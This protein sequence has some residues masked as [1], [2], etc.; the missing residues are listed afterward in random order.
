MK[1]CTKCKNPKEE[2]YFRKNKR[3]KDGLDL[4]CKICRKEDDIRIYNKNLQYNRKEGRERRQKSRERNREFVL[5]Y[6]LKHSCK[7]C[8][9]TDPIVLEFD[10][11]KNKKIT[12]SLLMMS[13]SLERLKE[14]IIKCEIRC[15]NCHRRKTAKDFNFFRYTNCS[16]VELVD[17]LDSLSGA[18]QGNS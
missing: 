4:Y 13:G 15:A 16:V 2:K 8:G 10:H 9:E 3:K 14:E 7:D 12:I 17:T 6:L 5:N 11:I 1:I 18:E